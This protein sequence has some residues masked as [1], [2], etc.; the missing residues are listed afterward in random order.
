[1]SVGDIHWVELQGTGGRSQK[2]RRPA[3]VIQDDRYGGRLPTMLVVPLTSSQSALRFAGTT[4]VEATH[5]SGLQIDSIALVFQC[6]AIDRR[7]VLE[8][9][10]RANDDER[11]NILAELAK[12][13]GQSD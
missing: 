12:L 13:T 2:G 7:Q 1:M 3:V 6:L 8:K 4:L 10:G 11:E 9:I 5:N